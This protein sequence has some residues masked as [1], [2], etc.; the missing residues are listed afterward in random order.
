MFWQKSALICLC[1]WSYH[2]KFENFHARY[3]ST[4]IKW[5][6]SPKISKLKNV[7]ND[8]LTF[9]MKFFGQQLT[10]NFPFLS[11]SFESEIESQRYWLSVKIPCPFP[12][13]SVKSIKHKIYFKQIQWVSGTRILVTQVMIWFFFNFFLNKCMSF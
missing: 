13:L 4:F 3:C 12:I 5:S 2:L 10:K 8:Y 11:V 7:R 6:P 1:N 9:E